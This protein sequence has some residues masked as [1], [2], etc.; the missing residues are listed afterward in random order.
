MGQ[1]LTEPSPSETHR[2]IHPEGRGFPDSWVV[3]LAL[4]L[5]VV[6]IMQARFGSL[7]AAPEASAPVAGTGS[8]CPAH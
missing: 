6:L 8:S 3:I 7:A 5:F 4:F 1:A 2:E